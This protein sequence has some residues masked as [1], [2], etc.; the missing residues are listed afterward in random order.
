MT[1]RLAEVARKVGV[2]EATVSRVLNGKPGVAE[3][4][5]QAVLTALDVLGYERPIEAPRRA[6]P[7]RRARP[8]RAPEPDLPGIRRGDGRRP[9]PARVHAR[10]LHADRGRRVGGRL[11]RAPPPAAGLGRRLRRR[12]VRAGGR[13]ARPLRAPGRTWAADGPRQRVDRRPRVPARLVR[14]RGRRRAGDG[15]PPLARP[16]PDRRAGGS[17]RPHPVATQDRRRPDRREEGG[18]PAR[19][20]SDRPRAGTRSRLPR[21]ARPG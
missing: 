15:P 8:A 3:P 11:R 13:A 6:S 2:S 19:S 5:R 17:R 7:A 14:R 4:T 20:G 12:P 18:H 16:H 1:R 10:P 9:R 21:P